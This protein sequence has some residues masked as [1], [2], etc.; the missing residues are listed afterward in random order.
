M[1]HVLPRGL[2]QVPPREF[3]GTVQQQSR[4]LNLIRRP[5]LCTELEEEFR[6]VKVSAREDHKAKSREVQPKLVAF[7]ES[8]ESLGNGSLNCGRS[9]LAL[10]PSFLEPRG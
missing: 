9:P 1:P 3:N 5:G 2:A 7:L 6:E 10:P 8:W 4:G